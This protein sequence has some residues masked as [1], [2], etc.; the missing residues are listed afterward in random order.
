MTFL[1]LTTALIQ[2][3][4]EVV[5]SSDDG[6]PFAL[7][8]WQ[9]LIMDV[10]E[11]G[12][13]DSSFA[14]AERG[15]VVGIMPLQLHTA[16]NVMGSSGWGGSGPVIV[17]GL[18]KKQRNR[19]MRIMFDHAQAVAR[20]SGAT[21]LQFWTSPVTRAS[22]SAAWGVSP[23]V[24]FGFNDKSGIAQVIDLSQTEN[25]LWRGIS[26]TSRHAVR[27]AV[28][29]GISAA[30]VSW[31]E[32]LEEYYST[33]CENYVRT[34]V[35]PHPR[36]YF[37]GIAR[38]LGTRGHAALFVARNSAGSAIA[39][40]NSLR[41]G[42][43]GCYHTGCSKAEALESGANYLLFW[44]A[45]K[46]AKVAGLKWYDCGEITPVASADKLSGLTAFKTKFGGEPHRFFKC[47][48]PLTDQSLCDGSSVEESPPSPGGIF[49]SL[50]SRIRN[51]RWP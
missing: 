4:D 19:V 48:M 22:A 2:T 8:C 46:A 34:G 21:T 42:I 3:W 50:R 36:M 27:K 45:L 12:L 1:P 31:T 47:E 28:A 41:F 20:N 35:T 7:S 17:S 37:E 25:S 10:R 43:G 5:N 13:S 32:M 9:R 26:E 30:E 11:W 18:S 40:H 33:H 6:W 14:V 29:A 15:K 39:F 24:F 38:E 49:G 16:S 44:E 23:F 51:R